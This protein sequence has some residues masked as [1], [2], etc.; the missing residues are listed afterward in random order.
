MTARTLRNSFRAVS[1]VFSPAAKYAARVSRTG[2][3]PPRE[4]GSG[5]SWP[6]SPRSISRCMYCSR[7]TSA[8][9]LLAVL[10]AYPVRFAMVAAQII[11]YSQVHADTKAVNANGQVT[12]PGWWSSAST[13]CSRSAHRS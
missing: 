12:V 8:S 9:L 10:C 13:P 5:L 4:V 1:V 7:R 2:W 11:A 3:A 6:A